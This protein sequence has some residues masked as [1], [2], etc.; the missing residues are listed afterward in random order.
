MI[1]FICLTC[2]HFNFE[3][4]VCETCAASSAQD[5]VA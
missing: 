3:D 1:D 4:D 2:G 5:L